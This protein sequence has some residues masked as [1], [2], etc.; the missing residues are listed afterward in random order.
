MPF[1]INSNYRYAQ[2]AALAYED[3]H[4]AENRCLEWGYPKF[5]FADHRGSQGYVAANDDEIAIVY[6]GTE[7]GNLKDMFSDA[8]AVKIDLEFLPGQ[9]HQ[10]FHDYAFEIGQE[11]FHTALKFH[12]NGQCIRSIGHSLGAIASGFWLARWWNHFPNVDKAAYLYGCPRGFTPEAAGVVNYKWGDVIYRVVNNNDVVTRV[13][14]DAKEDI[15]YWIQR[16]LPWSR[17][18]EFASGF[19]HIGNRLFYAN[20]NRSFHIDPSWWYRR[21]DRVGGR[22]DDLGKL[23]SDGMKDHFMQRYIDIAGHWK[24]KWSGVVA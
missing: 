24:Q 3:R 18:K 12:N 1:S 8:N 21:F 9:G 6:R 16:F 19:R 5:H 10:G 14:L 7:P 23:G 4:K 22:I 2:H 15:G 20:R 13:P 11:L 17:F